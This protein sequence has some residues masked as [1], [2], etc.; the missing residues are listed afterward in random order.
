MANID[1]RLK[2]KIIVHVRI[3]D[4][5]GIYNLHLETGFDVDSFF[6]YLAR[7]Y[8]TVR[9][10]ILIKNLKTSENCFHS[11]PVQYRTVSIFVLAF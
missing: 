11:V 7:A 6:F 9:Y 4:E 10:V 1:I 5:I 8:D 2:I 3:T